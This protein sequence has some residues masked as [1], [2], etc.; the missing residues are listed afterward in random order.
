MKL[1]KMVEI[2]EDTS[3]GLN[4]RERY[5]LREV[6][7]NAEHVVAM[8]S[9]QA[10][11]KKLHSGDLPEGLDLRQEFT[12]LTLASGQSLLAISVV[13]DIDVVSESLTSKACGRACK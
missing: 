13:G 6:V 8:R 11:L 3:H 1:V 4:S 7:V 10:L 12:K 2:Y 5:G 9:D